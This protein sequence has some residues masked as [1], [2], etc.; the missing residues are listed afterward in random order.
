MDFFEWIPKRITELRLERG[1]SAKGMSRSLGQS[2]SY[3]NKIEEPS[4]AQAEHILK[5]NKD[6]NKG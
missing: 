1:I 4:S 5:V 3:I 6:L 2:E